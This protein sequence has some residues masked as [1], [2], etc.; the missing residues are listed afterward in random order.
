MKH[1]INVTV[2]IYNTH[3]SITHH[4][5]GSVTVRAPYIR[6]IN[7]TGNLAFS[8]TKLTGNS[9]A[10]AVDMFAL[11]DM[12]IESPVMSIGIISLDDVLNGYAS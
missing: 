6:W 3:Y 1:Y 5:D 7:N 12:V 2:G 11:G 10:V 9:A 8:R 4:R